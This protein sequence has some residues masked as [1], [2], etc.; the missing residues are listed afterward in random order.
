VNNQTITNQNS[1]LE[2]N[3]G[4]SHGNN[5][6]LIFLYTLLILFLI[7]T[8][9][10]F[11]I[12]YIQ[13]NTAADMTIEL[14]SHEGNRAMLKNIGT[15]T[16]SFG[17]IHVEVA[18]QAAEILNPL[19]I[20]GKGE[21]K[22]LQFRTNVNGTNISVV[23]KGPSNT[24]SYTTDLIVEKP[25][26]FELN[27]AGCSDTIKDKLE[28]D[29]DCGG[30]ECPPCLIGLHCTNNSDCVTQRCSNGICEHP[31]S[32]RDSDR[33]FS[34]DGCGTQ[35]D[36]N[37]NASAI[38]P[39]VIEICDGKDNNCDGH[40]DESSVCFTGLSGGGMSGGGHSGGGGGG[41]D[42]SNPTPTPTPTPIADTDGDLLPDEWEIMYFGNLTLGQEDD[43][44]GDHLTNAQEY[45]FGA[46]PIV[47]DE[48]LIQDGSFEEGFGAWG[49]FGDGTKNII[50][51]GID[52]NYSLRIV[53]NGKLNGGVIQIKTLDDATLDPFYLEYQVKPASLGS[54]ALASMDIRFGYTDE[55]Y[56]F[57]IGPLQILRKDVKNPPSWTR[58]YA[59]VSPRK[60][61]SS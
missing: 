33:F 6:L 22:I 56:E 20:I 57:F 31:C 48:N 53:Q 12:L 24:V 34:E 2:M 26:D 29:V 18:G 30:S 54:K 16:I 11:V 7:T 60:N 61:V 50:K 43:P 46:N 5:R 1:P 28:T 8:I 49:S 23:I 44:D 19:D 32:D 25:Q 52:G 42:N 58:K 37:D 17:A 59:V 27:T 55:D 14:I 9:S 47:L 36:C 4:M 10:G 40:I 41:S 21:S 45:L 38:H 51:E 3:H 15:A 13:M 35:I 39:G